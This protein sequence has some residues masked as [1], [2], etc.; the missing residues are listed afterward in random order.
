MYDYL[1]GL[2][3]IYPINAV[4]IVEADALIRHHYV[5]ERRKREDLSN[6]TEHKKAG[7]KDEYH[8]LPGML[9]GWISYL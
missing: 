3:S 6:Y 5:E 1:T 4:V 2:V 9:I 8:R 7:V